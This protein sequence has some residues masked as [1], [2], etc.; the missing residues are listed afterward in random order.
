MSLKH[1]ILGLLSYQPMAGYDLMKVF[2]HS[3]RFFWN[4]QTSQIYRELDSAAAAGLIAKEEERQRGKIV[5]TIYSVTAAG[6]AEFERW[7]AEVPAE[8]PVRNVTLLRLFFH[9]RLGRDAIGRFLEARKAVAHAGIDRLRAVISEVI[10]S[11]RSAGSLDEQCWSMAAE[12]G[13]AQWEAEAR[14]AEA[15]LARLEALGK[16]ES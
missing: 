9:A 1:G 3:L 14:W 8:T 15:C 4:A 2:D 7:L 10:P 5:K 6:M 12:Y 13:I 11:Y 16:E